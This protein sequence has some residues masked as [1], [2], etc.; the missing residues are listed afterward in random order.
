MKKNVVRAG[1]AAALV[2]VLA[3]PATAGTVAGTGGSTEVTQILNNV[4]LAQQSLQMA[5]QV[6]NTITQIQHSQQQLRN[7]IAAPQMVW[8]N[9]ASELQ[10]LTQLLAKGQA[11]GYALGNIDQQFS[12]KYPG[13]NG[14]ALGNN[15]Q[16]ASRT[17]IQTS[18]DSM[19]AALRVAG[20]QSNQFANEQMAMDSIQGL[21]STA[22]G[23][24]QV[25]QAGVMVAG[26]QVQQ[27]QKLRQLFS[28]QMQAQNAYFAHQVNAQAE[29]QKT[30]D[31]HFQTYQRRTPTFSSSGGKK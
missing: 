23:A 10:Q 24:L 5:Q 1:L 30:A 14:A 22:P 3:V 29:S 11:L 4:E 15:F 31:D 21:A 6:Q 26:Q 13:Y 2:V 12:Q 27:L 17:W 20:L 16:A 9:A 8:G 25:S 7:L 19:S 18:L 28:A